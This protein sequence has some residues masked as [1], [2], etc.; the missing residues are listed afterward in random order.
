MAGRCALDPRL[1]LLVSLLL[2]LVLAGFAPCVRQ[3]HLRASPS[4]LI[5]KIVEWWKKT[6]LCI[7]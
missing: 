2:S 5:W 6:R 1:P 3:A 4:I 7:P